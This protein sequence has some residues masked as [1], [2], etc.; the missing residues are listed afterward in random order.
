MQALLS[1]I[2]CSGLAASPENAGV[3]VGTIVAGMLKHFDRIDAG[4]DQRKEFIGNLA[5]FASDLGGAAGGWGNTFAPII[6]GLNFIYQNLD[7]VPNSQGTALRLQGFVKTEWL[8]MGRA[9]RNWSK[10]DVGMAIDWMGMAL[11]NNG[12]G[13]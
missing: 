9:P 8:A 7:Q 12:F 5:G 11:N 13:S 2:D 10:V 6:S 1:E 4:V 3:L